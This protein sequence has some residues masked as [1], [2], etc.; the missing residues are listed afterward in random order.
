MLDIRIKSM[1][2]FWKKVIERP[3]LILLPIND[4]TNRTGINVAAMVND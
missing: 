2:A 3:L 1:L 4:P